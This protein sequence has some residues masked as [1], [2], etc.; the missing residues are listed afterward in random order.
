MTIFVDLFSY[1]D[2][3]QW[4]VTASVSF[5]GPSGFLF[6]LSTMRCISLF[7]IFA[8]FSPQLQQ[9]EEMSGID[10]KTIRDLR[11]LADRMRIDSIQATNAS[12]SG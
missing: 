7:D 2:V 8:C 4:K 10:E 9:K 3:Q 11:V 5:R 1:L 6:F 12:K